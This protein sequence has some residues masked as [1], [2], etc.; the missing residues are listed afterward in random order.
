MYSG[1]N[2]ISQRN[3]NVMTNAVSALRGK[4]KVLLGAQKSHRATSGLL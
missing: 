1:E 3:K 4:D 2:S